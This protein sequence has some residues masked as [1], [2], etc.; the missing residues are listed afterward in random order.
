MVPHYHAHCNE[1]VFLMNVEF[2]TNLIR[3]EEGQLN[4]NRTDVKCLDG[5]L[6]IS[7]YGNTAKL[8]KLILGPS[9][10]RNTIQDWARAEKNNMG[11]KQKM[12]AQAN[13]ENTGVPHDVGR[14]S[15]APH[16]MAIYHVAR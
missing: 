13:A 5:N 3:M 10:P 6:S 9:R 2:H 14:P 12:Q 1:E 4:S 16:H 11:P 7:K 8:N 15:V